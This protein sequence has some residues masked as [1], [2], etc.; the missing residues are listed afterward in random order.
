M[1][2]APTTDLGVERHAPGAGW[3]PRVPVW[4][5][6]IGIFLVVT[7]PIVIAA[8]SLIGDTWYPANDWA[9]IAH[10]VGQVGSLDTPLV[11]PYSRGSAH[12]GPLGLWLG[13]PLHWLTGGDTRSLAWS[14]ALVNV[15]VVAVLLG[16]AWRRGRWALLLGVAAL[17]G[18]L[19]RGFGPVVLVDLWNPFLP[20]LALALTAFL[21]WDAALGRKGS[22]VVAVVPASLAMQS[23]LGFVPLVGVLVAWLVVWLRWLSPHVG[24]G[25]SARSEL[26]F[27]SLWADWRRPVG[28][29]L[30]LGVVLW[31]APIFD[32]VAGEHNPWFMAR[33]SLGG[34]QRIGLPGAVGLVGRYVRP[35]G[36]WMGGAEPVG[37]DFFSIQGSGPVPFL[38][39]LA[40]L[41]GCL[42]LA[43]RRGWRDVVAL[44]TLTLTLVVAAVPVTFRLPL[45][46]EL[47][48]LQWLKVI[49]GLVWFTVGWT[50]WRQMA[51]VGSSAVARVAAVAVGVILLVAPL[52]QWGAASSVELPTAKAGERVQA[53]YADLDG[54]LSHDERIRVVQRGD[55]VPTYGAGLFYVLARD[56]YDVV[57]EEGARGLKWGRSYRWRWGEEYDRLLTVAV[58]HANQ[59]CELDPDATLLGVYDRLDPQERAWLFDVQLRRLEDPDSV[60]PEEIRRSEQLAPR[61]Q[62]IAVY[63]SAEP[64][65]K[66]PERVVVGPGEAALPLVVATAVMVTGAAG[67]LLVRHSH[68]RRAGTGTR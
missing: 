56:G 19:T 37:A 32:A 30:G 60:T 4:V 47:Y 10:R 18:V 17:V 38:V 50:A 7:S 8:F 49:G 57:T 63:E 26:S 34:G 44:S 15:T 66:D 16:V 2:G 28:Q 12:P 9:A 40:A 43:R 52:S 58:G 36:P 61:D 13:A 51:A 54:K 48:L 24:P 23:H 14:A 5:L 27:G 62:R 68:R 65:A 42:H 3:T 64:C 25:V 35:D 31:L 59:Q 21:V 20:L 67:W 22:L 29:S 11:G 1:T 41:A 46:A 55:P 33:S 39:A 53:L 45:P 6:Q